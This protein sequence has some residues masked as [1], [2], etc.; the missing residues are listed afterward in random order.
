MQAESK[1]SEIKQ[2]STQETFQTTVPNDMQNYAAQE[3]H[4]SVA[5]I[6]KNLGSGLSATNKAIFDCKAPA[7]RPIQSPGTIT[8]LSEFGHPLMLSSML[9]CMVSSVL[10]SI[11]FNAIL[12]DLLMHSTVQLS[13]T[14]IRS[15]T[16]S[17]FQMFSAGQLTHVMYFVEK[18]KLLKLSERS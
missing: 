14:R 10:P 4:D 1:Q 7:V 15:K 9:S 12:L 5:E 11:S 13:T 16:Q 8:N 2:L 3:T 18:K 6:V 17:S